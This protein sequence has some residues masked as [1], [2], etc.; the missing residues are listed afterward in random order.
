MMKITI[1]KVKGGAWK[2]A[3]ADDQPV[4]R[5]SFKSALQ[6]ASGQIEASFVASNEGRNPL[7]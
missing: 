7:H 2:S 4:S 1:Y 6:S 3:I 5:I